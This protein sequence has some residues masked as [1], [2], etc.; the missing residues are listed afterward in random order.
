MTSALTGGG[1]FRSEATALVS[2]FAGRLPEIRG[3]L[4]SD[5]KATFERDPA[6]RTMDEVL[7]YYPGIIATTHYRLAHVLHKLGVPLVARI[8]CDLARSI[9]GIDIHPGARIGRSFSIDHG[10]GVVIG[11]TTIVGERV[12]L[13]HGVTLGAR[14]LSA[15]GKTPSADLA[16]RHPIVEDDVVIYAGATI[17]GAITIGQGAI[18]GGNVWLT[19]SVSPGSI[20]SQAK[21]TTEDFEAGSGI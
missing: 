2:E 6:A 8:I 11:E 4:E 14:H 13:Y 16:G 9:T 7:V 20:V 1:K 17:L 18:I 12:H 5:I 21:V 10:T 19:D 15:D 3:L